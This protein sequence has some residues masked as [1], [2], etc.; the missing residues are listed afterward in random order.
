MR[1]DFG[2]ELEDSSGT[3]NVDDADIPEVLQ[4]FVWSNTL[5]QIHNQSS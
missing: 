1:Q 4:C 5:F 2:Q 3:Q